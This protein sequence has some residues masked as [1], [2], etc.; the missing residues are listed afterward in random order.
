[1]LFDAFQRYISE[2]AL[3][4]PSD[5][6]LAA[7]SGGVD[8]MVMLHLLSRTS[9]RTAVAH[10]NFRLRG[11][12]SDADELL[13]CE[14]AAAYGMPF[15]RIAFDTA[16]YAEEHRISI[17]MAARELRYA[18]FER[19]CRENGYTR[20]AVAHHGDDAI[21]TFFINLGRGTGIRGLTGMAH[22]PATVVRP[23]LFTDRDGIAAYAEQHGVTYREDASNASDKYLRNNIRHHLLPAMARIFPGYRDSMRRTMGLL[24]ETERIYAAYI[25]SETDRCMRREGDTVCIDTDLLRRAQA[26]R[27][28]LYE[29]LHPFGFSAQQIQHLEELIQRPDLSG[30]Q[31][32]NK[33]YRL[34]C[35]R[36]TLMVEPLRTGGEEG[37]F[38][39]AD[40]VCLEHP[41]RLRIERLPA[42]GYRL[43]KDPQ[44]AQFDADRVSF[45]LE[46]RHWRAG[47]RFCPLGMKGSQKLSD[48]WVNR[49]V[50]VP[51]KNRKWLLC[52][53][54]DILWIVG[55]RIDDRFRITPGTRTILK[56]NLC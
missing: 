51:E 31:L 34:W 23:M 3:L 53:G 7:V 11:E 27:T 49:K 29:M 37:C 42:A 2:S 22:G 48:Y 20:V 25:A 52:R 35:D 43:T 18:Y 45:P 32:S 30:K 9:F 13:V 40:T 39:D 19:L 55:E 46:L 10:C 1:M 14:T 38:I 28:L 4:T 44:V 15:H 36:Q 16:Q 50:P 12:A 56:I 5:R 21:E 6:I 26:P 24:S 41:I 47:D 54:G 33:Y 17:Q 8:S